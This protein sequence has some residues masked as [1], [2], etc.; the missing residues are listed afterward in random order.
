MGVGIE[1]RK[2]K[3]DVWVPELEIRKNYIRKCDI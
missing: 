3:K 1:I 2:K